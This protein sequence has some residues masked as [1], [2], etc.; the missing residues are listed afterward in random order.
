ME[1]KILNTDLLINRLVEEDEPFHHVN[2]PAADI[3][4]VIK[5][6]L[7]IPNNAEK[8]GNKI[9]FSDGDAKVEVTVVTDEIIRIR[10]APH[11]VFLEEFSY[12]VPKLEHKAPEFE[13]LETEFEFLVS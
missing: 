5:K 3:K 9:Y 10:L 1:E 8:T 4:P 11:G 13:L 7:G 2:N 12:A 6:Y